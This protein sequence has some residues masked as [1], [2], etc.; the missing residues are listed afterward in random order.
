MRKIPLCIPY[1]GQEEKDAVNEVI[2]SGWYAHGPKNHEFE[3]G[4]AEYL[5]VKHALSMNSCTSAIHLAVEGLGIT[6]EVILPSFTFVASANAVITGGA[7]PVFADI[8][9]D[10][11]NIDPVSIE[12]LITP[13][14]QA[15]MPVHFGGQSANMTAVMEIAEAHKFSVI[16]DSAETIGGEHHNRLTGTFGVGCFSFYPTKNLT[17]GEGGMLTTDDDDLARKVKTLL[18]HG[19]DKSTYE[20]EDQAKAWFRSA[21]QIGYNFRMSNILAAI[22]VEQLKKLPEMNHKRRILATK[23]SKALS[24]ISSIKL[25]VEKPENKHVYQMY[26]IRVGKGVDRD[27]FVR[28][29]NEKGIGA[30]IHFFPPVHHMKPY[31]GEK[32]HRDDLSITEQVIQEI[33]T[34]PMYPQ[35]TDDDLEY[36]VLSIKEI[37]SEF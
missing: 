18:A 23:L 25:P 27:E 37:L 12:R 30:S 34:L 13:E 32:Y 10:T 5:G 19:I 33:V 17:T 29:L 24:E 7:R 3:A 16:E 28:K 26:T 9:Y 11:C 20:R 1:T 36:M 35:M 31:R 6:G 21:S 2:D 4:F 15:I 22:G 8:E 14:T